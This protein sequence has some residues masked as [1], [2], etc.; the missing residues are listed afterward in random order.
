[1]RVLASSWAEKLLGKLSIVAEPAS[2]LE[3][4]YPTKAGW[5][6]GERIGAMPA[7]AGAIAKKS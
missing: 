6:G 4:H 7:W 2:A 3:K 5:E 1:M